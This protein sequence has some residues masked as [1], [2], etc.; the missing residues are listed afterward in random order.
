MLLAK[1]RL[2]KYLIIRIMTTKGTMKHDK[3]LHGSRD[4][5]NDIR[6]SNLEELFRK[7]ELMYLI[8]FENKNKQFYASSTSKIL[9]YYFLFKVQQS[10]FK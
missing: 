7:K 10:Y 3:N 4:E 2:W 8:Q 9:K 1:L 5:I 6:C